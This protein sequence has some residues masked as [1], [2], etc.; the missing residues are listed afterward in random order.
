MKKMNRE[1]ESNHEPSVRW[2][3]VEEGNQIDPPVRRRFD[4]KTY[5]TANLWFDSTL[6]LKILIVYAIRIGAGSVGR[7]K[8][9]IRHRGAFPF[10]M[11]LFSPVFIGSQHLFFLGINRNYRVF[12]LY[13]SFR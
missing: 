1:V 11:P 5:L 8:I 3:A 4:A 12:T 9:M 10:L 6:R 13:G 2:F 7:D